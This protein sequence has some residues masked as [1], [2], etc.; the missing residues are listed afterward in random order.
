M[1][2][3]NCPVCL[4]ACLGGINPHATR[5]GALYPDLQAS[6]TG[7]CSSSRLSNSNPEVSPLKTEN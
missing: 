6:S 4:S 5:S 3:G 1:I 2:L 7:F